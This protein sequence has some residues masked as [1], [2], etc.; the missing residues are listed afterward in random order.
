M[1]P[2]VAVIVPCYKVSQHILGVL[3]AIP[4]DVDHIF[5]VDDCCPEHS[6]Q[7]VQARVSDPRVKVIFN[8][9]NKGVGGAVVAG[10]RAA[11]AAGA[12]ILVKIDGD[13]QMDPALLPDFV[14]PIL[15]GEADYSKGNR[16]HSIWG[17]RGMPKLRSFG[18]TCLS[19]LT[20][21]SSGYW[22]IFDPT[23]GYTAVHAEAL[24]RFDLSS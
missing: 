13:G 4:P 3:E 16:F 11:L 5:V 21:L 24:E 19:F 7:L 17:L 18:N 1:K 12:E 14:N 2:S 22:S 9:A 10:Y 8:P 6:G 20:K 23:N 15:Y